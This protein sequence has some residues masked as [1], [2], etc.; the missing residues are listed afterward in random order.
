MWGEGKDG[1]VASGEERRLLR[2]KEKEHRRRQREERWA[3]GRRDGE[4]ENEKVA[5]EKQRKHRR[6]LGQREPGRVGRVTKRF[7]KTRRKR[8]RRNRFGAVAKLFFFPLIRDYDLDN[9]F[10]SV[11]PSRAPSSI[12]PA[13]LISGRAVSAS[14]PPAT[15]AAALEEQAQAAARALDAAETGAGFGGTLDLLGRDSIVLARMI[16]ALGTFV[17][18]AGHAPCAPELAA[19][20][21]DLCL[22]LRFHREAAVRRSVLYA[23]SRILLGVSLQPAAMS[24]VLAPLASELAAWMALVASSP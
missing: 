16:A 8:T 19:P 2:A 6:E 18:C 5:A 20:L 1:D 15:S 23:L 22:A 10:A 12:S 14:K 24:H 13:E 3:S 4:Q 21:L 9:S 11:Q 7:T 17:E